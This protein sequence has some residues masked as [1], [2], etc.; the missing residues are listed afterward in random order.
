LEQLQGIPG[1]RWR[2]PGVWGD[3]WNLSD[4]VGHLAEWQRMFLGW[5]EQGLGG[6]RPQMPAPGYSWSET[7]RL[8][9]AIRARNRALSRRAVLADLETGY[10]R[11]L[12]LAEA[13]SAEQLLMPGHFDWTGSHA[14]TTY[15]GANTASHYR[16]ALKVIKRWLKGASAQRG[17]ARLDD[18]RERTVRRRVSRARRTLEHES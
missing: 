1:V 5:Y 14:L 13:L 4:L 8:N 6:D 18:G 10:D 17:R 3:S 16:F 12:R 9:R 2:E 11:I 15:L 7:P